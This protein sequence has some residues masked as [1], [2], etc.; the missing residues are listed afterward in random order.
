MEQR[1]GIKTLQQLTSEVR[2][3][4]GRTEDEPVGVLTAY[5]NAILRLADAVDGLAREIDSRTKP[6]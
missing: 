4:L 2:T 1:T 3:I 6:R 5:R